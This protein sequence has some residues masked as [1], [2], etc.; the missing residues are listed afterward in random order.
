MIPVRNLLRCRE[1]LDLLYS[2]PREAREDGRNLRRLLPV[3][4]EGEGEAVRQRALRFRRLQ[5]R[6]KYLDVNPRPPPL[7]VRVPV[8]VL[9]LLRLRR[10]D[11]RVEAQHIAN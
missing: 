10:E 5:N 3:H 1:H 7:L 6:R 11:V 2:L 9:V 8:L 4:A